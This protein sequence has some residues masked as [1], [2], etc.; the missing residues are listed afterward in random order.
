MI[1][2]SKE[3]EERAILK[4]AYGMVTAARTAPKACGIDNIETCIL[5][6][7]DKKRLTEEMRKI[8]EA[9]SVPF[10]ARDADNVDASAC[11]VLLGV[12]NKP[13]G[14]GDC[15]CCGFENCGKMAAAGGRCVF[16]STDL[17]IAAGSAVAYAADHRIDNRIMFTA[18]KAA[19]QLGL[20]PEEV[21]LAYGIPL[22]AYGK[23]PYYDRK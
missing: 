21:R 22:S 16:N 5:D 1:Y 20:F 2:T 14:L 3:A 13:V 12:K 19:L 9:L 15:A 4:V 17:G 8:S 6:G 10:F 23:S 18:G 7:A 11:V